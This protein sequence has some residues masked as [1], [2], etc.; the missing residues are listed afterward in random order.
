MHLHFGLL[1]T[2]FCFC[3]YCKISID[4]KTFLRLY[5]NFAKVKKVYYSIFVLVIAF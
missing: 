4:N 1:V 2:L 5:F 3:I